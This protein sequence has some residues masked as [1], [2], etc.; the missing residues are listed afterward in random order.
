MIYEFISEKNF[1]KAEMKK[2]SALK[3]LTALLTKPRNN[4]DPSVGLM[5]YEEHVRENNQFRKLAERDSVS[6]Q[7]CTYPRTATL[8]WVPSDGALREMAMDRFR[9]HRLLSISHTQ[10]MY[11]EF[12]F[13]N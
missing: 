2:L 9:K 4:T 5:F 1:V 7:L 11:L 3:H 6:H 13:P 10:G 12:E 8:D